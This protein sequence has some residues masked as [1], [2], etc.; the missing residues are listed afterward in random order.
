M[1]VGGKGF[2]QPPYG[3]WIRAEKPMVKHT[4]WKRVPRGV[5][6]GAGSAAST[7]TG[8]GVAAGERPG[9]VRATV[10]REGVPGYVP[11]TYVNHFWGLMED[12]IEVNRTVTHAPLELRLEVQSSWYWLM[13][14]QAEASM[15][16]QQQ[17]GTQRK[18]DGDIL[19][20][21]LLEANP[22]LLAVFGTVSLLHMVFEFAA[23]SSDVS[24]WRNAKSVEGLSM[25]Q[26][27]MNVF[28]QGVILLYLWDNDTSWMVLGSSAVG[29]AIEV[30]KLRRAF[31][32][33]V[34]WKQGS[35]L[36]SITWEDQEEYAKSRAK[37]FDDM[38]MSHLG[39]VA[40]PL[41][42]GYAC[43][44]LL[45]DQHKSYY[46][47]VLSS[48]T[49][50]VYAFGFILM[51]PQLF[52]NY[53]LKSVAHMP[54]KAMVYRSLNTVV[55]DLFAFVIRMPTLHRIACFRDDVVFLLFL[56]QRYLY[57]VDP[58]RAN[59]YG[60]SGAD[61]EAMEAKKLGKLRVCKRPKTQRLDLKQLPGA[62]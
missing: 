59:E 54:W 11:V 18:Q 49:G 46:S 35:L 55:D 56:W 37:E 32:V 4:V 58:N 39:F 21:M 2:V 30:W 23:F 31:E 33:S 51:T 53:K 48:L 44:S 43:Y 15:S 8:K 22:I 50:F 20:A 14:S 42:V 40:F 25:K 1:P 34:E 38:A 17:M 45:Y 5:K 6:G 13:L 28:F 7:K 16:M 3:E 60:M 57:P 12:W 36:P 29:L 62:G 19:K 27:A 47:W 61:Y 41:V 10:E 26:I 9:Y 24:F 52:I